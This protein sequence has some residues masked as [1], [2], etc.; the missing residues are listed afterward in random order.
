MDLL[1]HIGADGAELE[2]SPH[3][4]YHTMADSKVLQTRALKVSTTMEHGEQILEGLITALTGDVSD[5]W[6]NSITAKFELILF[7]NTAISQ[8]S[9]AE[10]IWQQNTFL[11]GTI[12]TSVVEMGT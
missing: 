1:H 4:L 6:V 5:E 2:L 7:Q 11:H 9:M 12:A 3:S 8:I 10:L